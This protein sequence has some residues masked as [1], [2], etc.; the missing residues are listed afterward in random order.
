MRVCVAFACH[1][2]LVSASRRNFHY[3]AHITLS[4]ES[5][6]TY[7]RAHRTTLAQSLIFV[8]L[9]ALGAIVFFELVALPILALIFRD[10]LGAEVRYLSRWF[11]WMLI[12]DSGAQLYR[13]ADAKVYIFNPLLSL[14]PVVCAVGF[15]IAAF[16]S[17]L[18]P[19]SV[20]LVRKNLEREIAYALYHLAH[21]ALG[22][23]ASEEE[24]AA[25]RHRI[26]SATP[27]QLH[28][29]EEELGSSHEEL[30]LVQRSLLWAR[31]GFK[32]LLY[33][34]SALRLY[35]RNHFTVEYEQAVL[36]SIYVGA[37]VLIIIIGLRGL[38]FIPKER[39]SLVL[40]AIS[41]EFVLLIAY[42]LTLIFSRPDETVSGQPGQALEI[43]AA[44]SFAAG[45]L[46]SVRSAEKLLRMFI[47][48]PPP[49]PQQ[50]DVPSR[51]QSH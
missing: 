24:I 10:S 48:L 28:H 13:E 29:L 22:A 17:A 21:H 5:L 42:A 19:R 16:V 43:R 15:G 38:Q 7:R 18:L 4:M 46:A 47:A 51:E 49:N 12:S 41:L 9:A 36:G 25:L 40:F 27:E 45:P 20:G 11:E 1:A 31:G 23:V 14:L 2:E 3:H 26:E 6:A 32:R 33:L 50:N 30:L 44:G 34:G 8:V 35:L 39:P 37:A